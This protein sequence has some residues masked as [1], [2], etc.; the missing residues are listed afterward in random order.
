MS[1]T[2]Y[3]VLFLGNS[4]CARSIMAEAILNREGRGKFRAYS[5][6]IEAHAE[7]DPNAADLLKKM[8]F[9]VGAL[10]PK[11]WSELAGK[12]GPAFDFIFTLCQGAALLPR[13]MWQGNAVFAHWGIPNPVFAE[14]ND[15]EV[16]LAYAD[17][18]RML[19]NRIGIFVNLPLRS[20]DR[21]SMQQ[22]LDLIGNAAAAAIVA[23]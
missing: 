22:K 13:S 14:G 8:H 2:E 10:R 3:N 17:A 18:F 4:N 12:D 9:D 15:A 23:A 7:L 21:M 19:S 11:N 20:L 6:G 5:A 1:E 16:R